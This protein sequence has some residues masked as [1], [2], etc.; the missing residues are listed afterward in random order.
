[1]LLNFTNNRWQSYRPYQNVSPSGTSNSDTD[2]APITYTRNGSTFKATTLCSRTLVACWT[3]RCVNGFLSFNPLACTHVPPDVTTPKL[4][5]NSIFENHLALCLQNLWFCCRKE[6]IDFQLSWG[7]SFPHGNLSLFSKIFK[8]V[9]QRKWNTFVV[10]LTTSGKALEVSPW[11]VRGR[12]TER[13][14]LGEGVW[15]LA[16]REVSSAKSEV[17]DS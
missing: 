7:F 11:R 15:C 3:T 14:I 9:S 1:M 8:L 2:A 13:M 5:E 6:I 4:R 12:S 17:R 16:E 10:R